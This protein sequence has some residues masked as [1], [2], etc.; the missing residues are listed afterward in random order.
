MKLIFDARK[1]AKRKKIIQLAR[2][3]A[4]NYKLSW[5]EKKV[6]GNEEIK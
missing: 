3:F 5:L 6:M 2:L 4:K 1:K